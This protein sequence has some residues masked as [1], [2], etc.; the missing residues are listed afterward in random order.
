MQGKVAF[1]VVVPHSKIKMFSRICVLLCVFICLWSYFWGLRLFK[2]LS[3]RNKTSFNA[4]LCKGKKLTKDQW[5]RIKDQGH[6]YDSPK[7]HVTYTLSNIASND[8]KL[9]IG[10]SMIKA[11][12]VAVTSVLPCGHANVFNF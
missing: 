9:S 8:M 12:L 6:Y 3:D 7:L 5:L 4:D 11:Q 2:Y 10:F 1:W